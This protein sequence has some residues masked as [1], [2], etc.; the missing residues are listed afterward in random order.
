MAQKWILPRH[1]LNVLTSILM[2]WGAH[3]MAQSDSATEDAA[4]DLDQIEAEIVKPVD[5]PSEAA[6]GAPANSGTGSQAQAASQAEEKPPAPEIE[7]ISDLV[8]LAPFTDVTVLQKRYQPKSK[9]FQANLALGGITNDPWFMGMGLSGRFAYHFTEAWGI[10]GTFTALSNSEREAAK[11]LYENNRVST[12]SIVAT[13]GYMGIDAYWS[14]IYGKMSLQ[15]RRIIPFDMYFTAGMGQASVDGATSSSVSA[16][17]VGT[18]QIYAIN[19]S[20]G[21]RW[22][23]SWNTFSAPQ[24]DATTGKTSATQFNNLIL[25]LGGSFF[26]PEAKYR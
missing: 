24:K 6:G 9:R 15:N 1:S 20:W 11:E 3:A 2:L 21:F 26:F 18:G 22:D 12:S 4:S 5:G 14:P 17:H 25:M 10:E 8:K 7:K 23:F 19:K 13:K 16:F